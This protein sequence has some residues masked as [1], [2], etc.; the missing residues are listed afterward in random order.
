MLL[1]LYYYGRLLLNVSPSVLNCGLI[2][3]GLG[4]VYVCCV[5]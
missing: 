3:Q 4:C 1:V 5:K 2:L